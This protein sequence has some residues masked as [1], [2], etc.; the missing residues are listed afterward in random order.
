MED[1]LVLGIQDQKFFANPAPRLLSEGRQHGGRLHGG[2][3]WRR[4]SEL[5]L[6]L[7]QSSPVLAL[8]SD[9]QNSPAKTH[10]RPRRHAPYCTSSYAVFF[11]V[12]ASVQFD[13][14]ILELQMQMQKRWRLYEF[15]DRDADC[16]LLVR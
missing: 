7:S 15:V 4:Q 8:G 14:K 10:G 11:T 9:G 12:V 3:R 1:G 5:D 6:P 2:R 16:G 13:R